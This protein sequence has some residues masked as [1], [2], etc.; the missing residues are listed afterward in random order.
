MKA[1]WGKTKEASA[2]RLVYLLISNQIA[3]MS[4]I[5]IHVDSQP[6]RL[7]AAQES[8]LYRF[9]RGRNRTCETGLRTTLRG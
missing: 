9:D 3:L 5:G 1:Y 4:C 2:N 7:M 8:T 6:G